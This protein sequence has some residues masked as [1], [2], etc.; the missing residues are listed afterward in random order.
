VRPEACV[1]LVSSP[2]EKTAEK[3]A[4]RLLEKRLAACIHINGPIQSLY[5]WEERLQRSQEWQVW[6]KSKMLLFTEI[7]QEI[8]QLHP[9]EV[10]QIISMPIVDGLEPYLNWLDQSTIET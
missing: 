6:I 2:D 5:L 7:T 10:P 4:T 3:I 9:Y 8:C 1:I